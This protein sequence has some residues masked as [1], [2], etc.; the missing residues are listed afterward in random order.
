MC[1]WVLSGV[2]ILSDGARTSRGEFEDVVKDADGDAALLGRS[3]RVQKRRERRQQSVHQRHRGVA[4]AL[5]H[6]RQ[7]RRKLVQQILLPLI[8]LL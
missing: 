3:L 8:L 6:G 4:V 7:Q 1:S 5:E 2:D